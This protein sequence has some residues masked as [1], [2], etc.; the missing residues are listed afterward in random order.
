MYCV[1]RGGGSEFA[2]TV[3]W[4]SGTVNLYAAS[5]LEAFI[6]RLLEVDSFGDPVCRYFL[7]S[8]RISV[9]KAFVPRFFCSL[10]EHNVELAEF[11]ANWT[12]Q[13]LM[14]HRRDLNMVSI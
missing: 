7:Y 3:C 10:S 4:R 6:F 13:L 14:K 1:R 2:F 11:S 12:E 8:S 9:R 5:S